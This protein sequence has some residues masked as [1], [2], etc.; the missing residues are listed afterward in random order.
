MST[1]LPDSEVSRFNTSR[2]TDWQ[3][4]SPEVVE[5]VAYAQHVSELTDGAFDIT[6][7]PLVKLWGFAGE[8]ID[9]LPD[10]AEVAQLRERLGY[11]H[12]AFRR[13]PPALR[14]NISQLHIDLSAIAK[15]FAVDKAVDILHERGFKNYLIE[16][17]GELRASG[18]NKNLRVWHIGVEKP[19]PG[20]REVMREVQLD[21]A[22]IATS[23]DYRNFIEIDRRRYSHEIDP[24]S[25][26]PLMYQG[27]SVTVIA[28]T[29][30]QADAWATG[31]FVLGR[32]RGM[33]I[34]KSQQLAVYYIE[35]SDDGFIQT[36]NKRFS[37][38]L[39]M[40]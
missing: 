21:G 2:S 36:M 33:K 26:Q 4:V 10:D 29:A 28:P 20:W 7:A 9:K 18:V 34:A 39:A 16:V 40:E 13:T 14:K 24:R 11:Q 19:V 5:V 31:L 25:G 22:G 8:T 32:Q 15:G 6:V 12:L 23:G 27:G 30:M 3:A 35:Q 37:Q 38:H 1:Y 17:G